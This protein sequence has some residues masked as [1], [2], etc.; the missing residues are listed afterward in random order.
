MNLFSEM[1]V[2]EE[3]A[4]LYDR[5]IRVWGLDGQNRLRETKVLL[6]GFSGTLNEVCKNLVLGGIG[7]LTILD[8]HVVSAKDLLSQLFCRPSDL[9]RK[10][11]D[12]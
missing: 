8:D 7:K 4:V 6:I 12:F 10:V 11:F 2:T 9:G 1:N 5:Q 3:E